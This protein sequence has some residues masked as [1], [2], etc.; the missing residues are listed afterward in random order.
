MECTGGQETGKRLFIMYVS[1][2]G[3]IS[4]LF[5]IVQAFLNMYVSEIGRIAV[6]FLIVLYQRQKVPYSIIQMDFVKH[7]NMLEIG[8]ECA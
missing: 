3:R 1:E 7:N 4:V 6:L 8:F 5:F 2:R